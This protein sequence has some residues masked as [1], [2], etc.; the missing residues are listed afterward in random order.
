MTFVDYDDF[1]NDGS[2]PF[3]SFWDENDLQSFLESFYDL[4]KMQ[5]QKLGLELNSNTNDF[6]EQ[7]DHMVL[8][9]NNADPAALDF[10]TSMLTNTKA[11]KKIASN[12]NFLHITSDILGSPK[13]RLLIDGPTILINLPQNKTRLYT[14][15]AESH[16]YPKRRNF[17]NTWSPLIRPKTKENGTMYVARKSHKQKWDFSEF[18]GFDK[19][20]VDDSSYFLQ[21][22]IPDEEIKNLEKIPVEINPTDLYVFHQDCVH[23]ASVNTSDTI[24][25]SMIMKVFDF[26]KDLTLSANQGERPYRYTPKDVATGR[27]R[28]KPAT[29]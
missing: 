26:T 19:D 28:L 9:L 3:T 1:I 10:V 14:W 29:Y 2:M 15:H 12:D 25:Y 17:L 5:S 22:E 21:Y 27:P 4:V 23:A 13:E 7:L 20:S 18:Y 24:S 11:A 8:Q 16:W 6:H